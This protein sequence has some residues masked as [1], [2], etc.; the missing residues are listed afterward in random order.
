V[1]GSTVAS[2]ARYH[3]AD[4][5]N[6]SKVSLSELLRIIELYNFREGTTRT[7]AYRVNAESVDGFSTGPRI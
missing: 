6:D 3:S 1:D 4:F 2:L 5:D 7:G